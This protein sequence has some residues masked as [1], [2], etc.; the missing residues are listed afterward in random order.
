MRGGG[1]EDY[2]RVGRLVFCML[3]V[4]SS[5]EGVLCSCFCHVAGDWSREDAQGREKNGIPSTHNIRSPTEDLRQARHHDIHIWQY[6]NI[7]KRAERLVTGDDEV[8]SGG[9]VPDPLEVWRC[10]LWVAGKF[11]EECC[12][13]LACLESG[14]EVIEFGDGAVA[15]E[16]DAAPAAEFDA[17]HGLGVGPSLD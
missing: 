9:E 15:V 2:T 5:W 8:V 13:F 10:Q 12:E 14:F 1:G 17:L 6:I 11:A 4:Y 7:H 3:Y 16:D